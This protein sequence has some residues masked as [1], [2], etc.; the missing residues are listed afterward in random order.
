MT[1]YTI[2]AV[3]EALAL[4]LLVS[5]QPGLGVTELANRSGNTKAR[6]FRLLYTLEQRGFVQR[7]GD[8]PTYILGHRA[9]YLGVAAQ[10]QVGLVRL[11]RSRLREIGRQCNENVQL[12]VRDGLETICIARWES[13]QTLRVHSDAANRRPL[14]A[15]ASGKI[16]LAYAPDEV[17]EAV[18]GSSLERFTA[19]TIVQR[20]K[21]IQ[22][23]SRIKEKG[24]SVSIGETSAGAVA[25][26]A[27][28]FDAHGEMLAALSIAGPESRLNG[29]QLQ[30]VIDLVVAEARS[31][32]ASMG[33]VLPELP[34]AAEQ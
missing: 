7:E 9:L 5:Q 24:Y 18:L 34:H 22:E 11:A 33:F 27:A 10:D 12:R 2:S 20:S 26:A 16:L 13:T 1:D 8:S 23:I 14:H 30:F 19:N 17:R 28:V 15:G 3:D 4:L 31:L 21:L 29:P 32:S 6:S 25:V